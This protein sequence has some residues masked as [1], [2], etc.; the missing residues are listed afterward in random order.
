M[1]QPA[2]RKEVDF[3]KPV[4]KYVNGFWRIGHIYDGAF[5]IN[6]Y[7]DFETWI[8]AF[9]DKHAQYH[10]TFNGRYENPYIQDKDGL[11]Y[12]HAEMEG[13]YN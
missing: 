13:A 11:F 6:Q 9:N 5:Y 3:G 12:T 2:G 7:T 1:G 10:F 4:I 8:Q